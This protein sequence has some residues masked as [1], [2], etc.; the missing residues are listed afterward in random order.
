M[1]A[2]GRFPPLLQAFLHRQAREEVQ[3]A[4]RGSVGHGVANPPQHVTACA[5]SPVRCC[6]HN[7]LL[8]PIIK[9]T[10]TPPV[11]FTAARRAPVLMAA[12]EMRG[13]QRQPG[14]R[15]PR[16]NV[17]DMAFLRSGVLA[18]GL[19]LADRLGRLPSLGSLVGPG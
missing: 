4:A 2:A 3:R 16:I 7:L 14:R 17:G 18:S 9:K 12:L 10:I 19:A 13:F 1:A 6:F 8:G 11:L 5:A 15:L